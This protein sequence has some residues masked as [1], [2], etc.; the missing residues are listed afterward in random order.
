MLGNSRK[1][2]PQKNTQDSLQEKYT[3]CS[4]HLRLFTFMK[5]NQLRPELIPI[6][7]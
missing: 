1:Y 3:V 7:T 5:Q 6:G 2:S 4:R